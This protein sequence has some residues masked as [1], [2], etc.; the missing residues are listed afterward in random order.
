MGRDRRLILEEAGGREAFED[1]AL[2][3]FEYRRRRA[4]VAFYRML[5]DERGG[6][7]LDLACGTG[8]I[9]VPLL[10]DGHVVVGVD[11]AP[12][13]LARCA[14]R[15]ARL[16]PSR[17]NRALLVRAD[18]RAFAFRPR[19]AM[20]L[21]AFHSIQHLV[22][23]RDLMSLLRAARRALLPGG[24]LVFDVLPPDARLLLRGRERRWGRTVFRHPVTGQRL[25]YTLQAD[26][27]RE[28]RALHMR[29]SYL[30][31]DEHGAPVGRK[32][33]VR[34]CHRQLTP[35][36]VRR[37]LTRAGFEL[38]QSW[39]GFDGRPLDETADEN[40]YVARTPSAMGRRK[41]A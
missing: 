26:Y 34:I 19:F 11:R 18:L 20:V 28:R 41:T 8:R 33:I 1:A 23:D 31:V 40:I 29:I 27:H 4:D 25:E 39:G 38:L 24:W 9:M 36:D 32:R 7:I 37:L 21:C 30:P 6:P 16:S 22:E 13:M 12:A 14:R 3:D 17:R 10:R 5:A 15:I 2:Y 35:P